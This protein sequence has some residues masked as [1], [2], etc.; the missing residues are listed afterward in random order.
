VVSLYRSALLVEAGFPLKSGSFD[1]SYWEDLGVMRTA[2][3][4]R[5][6]FF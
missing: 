6:S 2:I 4:A 1:L 5:S 3:R